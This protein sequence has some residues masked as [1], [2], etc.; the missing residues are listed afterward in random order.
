MEFVLPAPNAYDKLRRLLYPVVLCFGLDFL[1]VLGN[2]L[3][4]VTKDQREVG[5]APQERRKQYK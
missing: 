3:F 1:N 5:G 2:V 4:G